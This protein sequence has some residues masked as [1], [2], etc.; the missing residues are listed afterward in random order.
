MTRTVLVLIS[1]I[2]LGLFLG[3]FLYTLYR[4]AVL[5]FAGIFVGLVVVGL[6]VEIALGLW[7]VNRGELI[8]RDTNAS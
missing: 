3:Y 1:A 5:P 2:C 4:W 6:I 8:G 7:V